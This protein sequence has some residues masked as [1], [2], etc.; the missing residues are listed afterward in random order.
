MSPDVVAK[1]LAHADSMNR[2]EG[3]FAYQLLAD[4]GYSQVFPSEWDVVSDHV[5]GLDSAL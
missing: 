4:G 2:F 3:V 5:Q 1:S